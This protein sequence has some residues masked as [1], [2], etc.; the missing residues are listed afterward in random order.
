MPR[1][2]LE[3]LKNSTEPVPK[4]LESESASR[5]PQEKVSFI[6]DKAKFDAALKED[7]MA[8]DKLHEGISGFTKDGQALK[9]TL[10]GKLSA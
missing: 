9:D 10:R 6:N 2:L 1:Q 3:E 8:D 4:R 7:K 5:D